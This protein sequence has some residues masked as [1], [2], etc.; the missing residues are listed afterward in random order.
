MDSFRDSVKREARELGKELGDHLLIIEGAGKFFRQEDIE[1]ILSNFAT[2]I[3]KLKG[4][5]E[6]CPRNLRKKEIQPS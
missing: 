6:R 2:R 1:R 4:E 3:V 5:K